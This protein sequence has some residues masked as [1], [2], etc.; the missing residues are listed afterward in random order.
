MNANE[1]ITNEERK[2]ILDNMETLLTD[3]GYNYE[4]FAL[5][6]IIDTWAE[7]KADLITHF[8]NHPNYVEGKFMIA[9]DHD[10]DRKA[11]RQV[12]NDFWDWIN[13]KANMKYGFDYDE[14]PI[15]INM[16]TTS[17]ACCYC[18]EQFVSE[19]FLTYLTNNGVTDLLGIRPG[20]KT[21]RAVNKILT[22]FGF[23]ENPDYNR[24][25][26]KYSDAINPLKIVRHTIISLN[27]IDYLTMS[28]GNSWASCH[29]IDKRNIRD[30]PN[31]Y[32][33]MYSSGTIS[34]MLDSTTMVFYTVDA[35]YNGTDYFFEDKINRNMFHYGEEKL[36]QG[37]LYPQCNDSGSESIYKD[38]REI[39]QRVISEC[40]GFANFWKTNREGIQDYVCSEGTHYRDYNAFDNC[41]MSRL[42]GSE[43]ENMITIGHDP[44]CIECGHE[45]SM[46]NNINHCSGAG[47]CCECGCVIGDE[48][49]IYWCHDDM[50]CRDC[51]SFC[52]DCEEYVPN[53][54]ITNIGGRYEYHYVCDSCLE[55]YVRCEN[56]DEWIPEDNG[57]SVDSEDITVCPE[58]YR[59]F[60]EECCKCG[61]IFRRS[62]M[63]RDSNGN[64]ICN[65]C[66][67]EEE[68]AE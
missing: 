40:Y 50:Y 34:Y 13:K 1:I 27:P 19:E 41:E 15:M 48:D 22:H 31:N 33:G 49:D 17:T 3:Y 66:H 61:E 30:M 14:W 67:E 47:V 11:D 28:F 29:T 9:F 58:C 55:N 32:Q 42:K 10:Y 63:Y 20:M 16:A 2:V 8:K 39:V 52:E 45:H 37:R 21:S 54:E 51:V 38:I 57:Y 5:N 65:D 60:F 62:Y 46:E 68:E 44:I 35:A 25:F 23:D 7:N 64:W 53:G 56:C 4:I 6:K 18:S 12:V 59:E 24:E 26:A 36:V 43:N